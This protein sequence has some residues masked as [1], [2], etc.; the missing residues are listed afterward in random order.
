MNQLIVPLIRLALL[1]ALGTAMAV[2]ACST[3]GA[4][5]QSDAVETGSCTTDGWDLAGISTDGPHLWV[6][7]DCVAAD[8]AAAYATLSGALADASDGALILIGPGDWSLS[9]PVLT[10]VAFIGRGADTVIRGSAEEPGIRVESARVL[11]RDL[12]VRD[13][14][15]VG[16]AVDA[17]H[18]DMQRVTVEGTVA[19]PGDND[20]HGVQLTSGSRLVALAGCHFTNNA[21][22]GVLAFESALW[23]D[24]ANFDANGTGGLSVV[25]GTF[26]PADSLGWLTVV[27]GTFAP[28]V[29][30]SEF[31][32]NTGVGIAVYGGELDV[33]G[34]TIANTATPTS[35][36][37]GDGVVVA[38]SISGAGIARIDET[39]TVADN[40]RVGAL[41]DVGAQ[42]VVDGT[43]LRNQRS[44]AWV[45]GSAA[46]LTIT[47]AAVFDQNRFA[48]VSATAGAALTV[49]G[50]RIAG[51]QASPWSEAILDA[52]GDG[53]AISNGASLVA[54]GAELVDNARAGIAARAP[55]GETFVVDGTFITGSEYGVALDEVP[56]EANWTP[57]TF[58]P[59]TEKPS[60][61]DNAF[62]QLQQEP[63]VLDADLFVPESL[64]S[65]GS[66]LPN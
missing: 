53:L 18:V 50:A 30:G 57:P 26:F 43:F 1:C 51:T 45:Q 65:S 56:G 61:G 40:D 35:G 4:T 29:A 66:C 42:A 2:A 24:G 55:S 20:G 13:S 17:S 15:R 44:G 52:P 49:Q 11:L 8:G 31:D 62:S 54:T 9:D 6:G 25:D 34:C 47:G 59:G 23:V 63:V 41:V 46:S 3:D 38:A 28:R 16:V 10:D 19:G 27:D 7:S 39:T 36:L 14:S 21:G 22:Y 32:A 37:G 48:G 12:H 5:P 33:M 58:E 60:A 64:C